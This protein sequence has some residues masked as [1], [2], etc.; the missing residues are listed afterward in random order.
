VIDTYETTEPQI[1]KHGLAF[2]MFRRQ[3]RIS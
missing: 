3:S 2:L 1:R